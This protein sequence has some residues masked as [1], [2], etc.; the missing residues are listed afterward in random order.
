[1]RTAALLFL[2]FVLRLVPLCAQG[3]CADGTVYFTDPA[4]PVDFADVVYKYGAPAIDEWDI[5]FVEDLP[6]RV[7]YPTDLAPGEQR[8]LIVL[9][10]GGYFIWGDYLDFDGFAKALAEKGFIAAT[11]EYRRCKRADCNWARLA[12]SD[13]IWGPVITCNVSWASSFVPSAYVATVDVNDGIRWLQQN[14]AAYHIDPTKI[15]VAGHSAGGFTALN[16]A[17]LDQAE[18]NTVLPNVG[19]PN[20]PQNYLLEPLDPVDGIRACIPMSGAILNLDWIEPEEVIG[21]NI[22]VGIVHGTSDGVAHYDLGQAI[23]CCQT[24]PTLVNGA[25]QVAQR[26]KELGGNYYLLTGEGFGHDIAEQPWFDTLAIQMPAFII[27]TILCGESVGQ[28]SKVV[29]N[30]PLPMCLGGTPILPVAPLCAVD[31]V[32]SLLTV[33]AREV[34]GAQVRENLS[35]LLYP[36]PTNGLLHLRSLAGEADG[37][38]QITFLSLDGRHLGQTSLTLSGV[39]TFA[40][41]DEPASAYGL[42]FRNLQTGKFGTVWVNRME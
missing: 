37:D 35:L 33:P 31:P 1:M 28:H 12:S 40:L 20:A 27:K 7:Y 14:A 5:P 18:F 26:V 22:A 21:E 38:W 32:T 9:I 10:H 23:P 41:P 39:A 8:P 29:R 19:T 6:L 17:F 16:V 34:P 24:Y 15:T 42:L 4:H 11:V 3:Y 36:N 30:T 2:F 25:C 13:P